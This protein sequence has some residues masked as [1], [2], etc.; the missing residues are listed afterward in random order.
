MSRDASLSDFDASDADD[1]TEDDGPRD[2]E[3][4]D[5]STDAGSTTDGETDHPAD[6]EASALLDSE[7]ATADAGSASVDADPATTSF[8]WSPDGAACARCGE[9]VR[10]RWR[11]GDDVVC[12]D[13][14]DW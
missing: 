8:A 1:E 4:A 14:K 2:D 11:D 6:E 9:T 10:R 13:C 5:A 7:S 12:S 3:S